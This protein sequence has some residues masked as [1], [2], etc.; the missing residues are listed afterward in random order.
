M[1]FHRVVEEIGKKD[2]RY[3]PDAYEFV[4]HALWRT[5]KKLKRKGHIT[6]REL[7]EGIKEFGLAQYGPMTTAVFEHWGVRAT[8]DFGEIVFNMVENGVMRKT[9]EDSLS[10]FKDVYDFNKAFNV[11]DQI[12]LESQ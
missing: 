8:E 10:D 4:M 1:D 6:G 2:S 9:E 7:L 11:E 12:K 3:K 5:Q